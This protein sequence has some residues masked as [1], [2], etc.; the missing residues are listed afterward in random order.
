KVARKLRAGVMPPA[1]RPRPDPTGY[2]HLASW[3]EAGLDQA[4]LAKP[5]AGRTEPFHRLNRAEYHNAVRDLLAVDVDAAQLLPPDDS[6]YGFD[7][8]A[9]V[10]RVSPTLMERY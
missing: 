8:V 2:E 9:A 1:G 5:N 4:A 10:Q 6:S 7:N 3:L